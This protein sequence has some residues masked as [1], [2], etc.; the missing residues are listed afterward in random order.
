MHRFAAALAAALLLGCAADDAP[1]AEA[2]VKEWGEAVNARDWQRAC[3]LST[4]SPKDC[5][6]GLR[7]DFAEERLKFDGPAI[8]GGE[9]QPGER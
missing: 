9:M 1:D 6:D 3:E 8:N 7:G 4:Q 5:K 2:V